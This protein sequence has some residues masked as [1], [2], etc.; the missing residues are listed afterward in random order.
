MQIE[1][2]KSELSNVVSN[3]IGHVTTMTCQKSKVSKKVAKELGIDP[4]SVMK[5][6]E[7]QVQFGS[8]YSTRVNNQL[9][10]ENK[11]NNFEAKEAFYKMVAGSL[12]VNRK[13]ESKFYAIATP[14]PNS[15][16]TTKWFI[17]GKEVDYSMIEKI[18][19]PS[20]LKSYGSRQGTDKEIKHLAIGLN[21]ITRI[22]LNGKVV[23]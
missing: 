6:S 1:K 15:K 12:A 5:Q 23:L 7:I 18:F 20:A 22:A 19:N 11:E 14:M 8:N 10:R 21:S 17:N 13:D 2:I 16:G 4:E 3:T 9:K